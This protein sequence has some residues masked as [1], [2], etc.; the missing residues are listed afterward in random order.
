MTTLALTDE[1]IVELVN[2]LP[3]ER[4]KNVL[5]ALAKDSQSRQNERMKYAENQLRFLSKKRDLDWDSM[6]EEEKEAFIDDIIHEDR[7]CP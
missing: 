7:Q 5:F 1:Q 4:K 6:D 3:P 2:Q